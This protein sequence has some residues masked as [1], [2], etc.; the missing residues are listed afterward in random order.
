MMTTKSDNGMK[1]FF[2]ILVACWFAGS[3]SEA[4]ESNVEYLNPALPPPTVRLILEEAEQVVF[5]AE[6]AKCPG[7]DEWGGKMDLPDA[8][9]RAFRLANGKI[10]ILSPHYNNLAYVTDDFTHI[11]HPDCHSMFSSIKSTD[12]DTFSNRDW[13]VSAHIYD[14]GRIYGLVHN[15]YWGGQY[16][17]TCRLRLEERAYWDSICLYVNLISTASPDNGHTFKL[18]TQPL[19]L[20]AAFPYPFAPDMGRVGVRDPSNILF[21]PKDGNLYFLAIVDSYRD[22]PRGNC[23]FRSRDPLTQAWRA[24]DGKKFDTVMGSPYNQKENNQPAFCASV[25][26]LNMTTLLYSTEADTFIGFGY[27]ER[28]RPGGLFYRTSGDL[29]HWSAPALLTEGHS[30]GFWAPGKGPL[31]AYPSL[32][33]PD[34]SGNNFDE[35]GANGFLFFQKIRLR[36]GKPDARQRDIVRR[37]VKIIAQ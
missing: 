34:S 29:I 17:I 10:K 7:K 27:E 20:A 6:D 26:D 33:D 28:I 24:W 25:S 35:I 11:S 22:Q 32:L 15:E 2:L 18:L 12:P 1:R 4:T 3:H 9:L 30:F 8:P 14:D 13:L 19:N 21:N 31:I 5:A 23:L 37:Q 16:N 36:D